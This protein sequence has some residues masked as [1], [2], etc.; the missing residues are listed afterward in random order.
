MLSKK[1]AVTVAVYSGLYRLWEKWKAEVMDVGRKPQN[2]TK[3]NTL[4]NTWHSLCRPSAV[5][6]CVVVHGSRS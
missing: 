4:I 5:L 1:D 6:C 2:E 3:L